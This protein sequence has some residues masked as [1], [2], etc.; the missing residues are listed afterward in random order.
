MDI[1]MILVLN[2]MLLQ[3]MYI[4]Y[5]QVFNEKMIQYKIFGFVK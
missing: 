2:M 3:L 4:R 5:S 1:F